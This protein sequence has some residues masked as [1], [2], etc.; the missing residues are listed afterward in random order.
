VE[1]LGQLYV[2]LGSDRGLVGVALYRQP[3][4]KPLVLLCGVPAPP[5]RAQRGLARISQSKRRRRASGLL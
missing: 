1:T 3:P 2:I 5:K 4:K